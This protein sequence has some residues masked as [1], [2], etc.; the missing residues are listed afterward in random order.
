MARWLPAFCTVIALL[1]G[2]WLGRAG[3][4]RPESAGSVV[5]PET[6]EAQL[7]ENTA[8]RST[9]RNGAF[10]R[11]LA[12]FKDEGQDAE[13]Q[14]QLFAEL[15][16]LPGDELKEAMG[17]LAGRKVGWFDPMFSFAAWWAERDLPAA[18]EWAL[19]VE[20]EPG[21]ATAVFD[22]WGRMNPAEMLDWVEKHAGD[23]RTKSAHKG[24]REA[25]CRVG[26]RSDP[27]RGLQLLEVLAGEKEIRVDKTELYRAWAQR[28]PEAAAARAE[29]EENPSTRTDCMQWVATRWAIADLPAA[30]EWARQIAD[31]VVSNSVQTRIG[32]ALM[33]VDA[34]RAADH[35]ARLPQT[36]PTRD[37]LRQVVQ[38]WDGSNSVGALQWAAR[39]AFTSGGDT[40]PLECVWHNFSPEEIKGALQKLPAEIRAKTRER[41]AIW[42]A[43][44][45]PGV[46]P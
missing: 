27:E 16:H 39:R 42:R 43:R 2:W 44:E 13:L 7:A 8:G 6:G 41:F 5:V 1:C 38:Q 28:D 24:V 17:S 35:L 12:K 37:E 4:N 25:V 34:W 26:G 45:K 36:D 32:R 21:Y 31:P 20:A 10:D 11:I 15:Q 3:E 19:D 40:W 30:Q 22:T 33:E 46:A 9:A 14:V 29:L 18:R 23:L